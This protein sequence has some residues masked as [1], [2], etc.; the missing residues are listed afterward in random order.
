MI[1]EEESRLHG[2]V[3]AGRSLQ[4]PQPL[5]RRLVG[6]GPGA[7]L[8]GGAVGMDAA[9]ERLL[10]R[11]GGKPPP[12]SHDNDDENTPSPASLSRLS[13]PSSDGLPRSGP[14]QG[15]PLIYAAQ[16]HRHTLDRQPAYALARVL[17]GAAVRAGLRVGATRA[18]ATAAAGVQYDVA[19]SHMRMQTDQMLQGHKATSV[20][21]TNGS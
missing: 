13:S 18:W 11:D 8:H 20:I 17:P 15:S 12:G 16:D 1:K 14:A 10:H 19:A 4:S 21:I 5:L 3:G 9:T 6:R 7:D 2:H